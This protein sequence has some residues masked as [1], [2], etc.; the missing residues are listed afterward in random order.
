M[1][2]LDPGLP[3]AAAPEPGARQH[4]ELPEGE[5]QPSQWLLLGMCS[6]SE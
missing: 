3:R 1:E 2:E 5:G 4:W 6:L